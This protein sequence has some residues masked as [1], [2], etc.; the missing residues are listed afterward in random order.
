M[1]N[2]FCKILQHPKINPGSAPGDVLC[3]GCK[4]F[5]DNWYTNETLFDYL[6][7]NKTCA[8]GTVRKNRLKLPNSVTNEKLGR[9]QFTFKR[10]ENMLVV[11]YQ[12]KKQIFLLS[13]MHK[14]DIVNVRKRSHGDVQ[15]PKVIHNY[16]QKMGG[17]NKNDAMI[18]NYSCIRKTY[19]RYMIFFLHFLEDALYN[20]FVVYNKEG[21]KKITNFMLFK[22]E[23][24]HEMLEDLHQI[25]ADSES[26][27]RVSFPFSNTT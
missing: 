18:G 10:K 19:K 12:D 27:K 23:V 22:L 5:V 25:P 2:F 13:T 7:E 26:F 4:L 6:Y 24:I 9:G 8:V 11:C 20:A 15:K 1:F 21:E 16:N 3:L 17:V 14:P